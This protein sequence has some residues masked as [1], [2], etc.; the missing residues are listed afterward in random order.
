MIATTLVLGVLA[1]M[2]FNRRSKAPEASAFG[3]LVVSAMIYVFGY[4]GEVSATTLEA[5]H[6]WLMFE[7]IG[8]PWLPG[9]WLLAAFRHNG[10]RAPVTALFIVPVIAFLGEFTNP[11]LGLFHKSVGLV[12]RGPFFVLDI[13]RGPLAILDNTYLLLAC[14][15]APWLYISRFRHSSTLF[16][17]QATVVILSSALPLTSYFAYLAGLSPY[18]L[19]IAPIALALSAFVFY[20]GV[21]RLSTFDLDPMARHLVF[22]G[23]RDA[24]VIVDDQDRLLDFN[25]AAAKLISELSD[26]A[27]G[28]PVKSV[29]AR[30]PALIGALLDGSDCEIT[31]GSETEAQHYDVRTFPLQFRKRALGNAII[32][33]DVTSQTNLREELRAHAE[34]DSLTGI[35]NRR[36]FLEAMQLECAR[37]NR[38]RG[39]FSVLLI[40]IDRFKEVNDVHGHP[41][42]DAV[43]RAVV[44]RLRPCFR[45]IDLFARYGGEEFSVLLVEA[46]SDGAK[47]V[48]E[49]LRYAIA[50]EPF[51]IE[52]VVLPITVSIGFVTQKGDRIAD[53]DRLLK[54]A[55]IALYLAKAEGRNRVVAAPETVAMVA[56]GQL[57]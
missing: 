49:N 43:L 32:L 36:R 25:A 18:G 47:E 27:V 53:V 10:R 33:A 21:F 24:V 15:G 39:P 29:L 35:A 5:A 19:D 12:Q 2:T 50:M 31:L 34:T 7:Q 8:L 51:E 26:T 57:D 20:Y 42:G 40:D 13:H 41:A 1:V 55:D 44:D 11:W 17:R 16:K 28:R 22:N 38:Y 45:E 14:L 54:R 30:Y 3:W 9:F 4:A 52:G 48:A 6:H 23:I 56:A 46:G 37:Y